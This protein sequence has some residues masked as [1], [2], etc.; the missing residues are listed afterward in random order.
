VVAVGFAALSSEVQAK[1]CKEPIACP[2]IGIFCL[3]GPNGQE[4]K[5][6]RLN[7]CSCKVTCVP[8]SHPCAN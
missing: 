1:D 5:P 7:P 4:W 8:A 3:P 2:A 6:C